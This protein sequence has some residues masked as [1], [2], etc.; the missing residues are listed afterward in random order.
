MAHVARLIALMSLLALSLSLAVTPATANDQTC[1]HFISAPGSNTVGITISTPGIYCLATDVIM[2]ASF[3][4]GN[5]IEIAANYV[6]L[7]L[8]GHKVHGA[9][10]GTATQAIGIHAANRQALTIKNG[11]VWGFFQG[12][13]LDAAAY[14]SP[15]G[16]V[17]EGLRA[18]N[19][20][21][22]GIRVLGANSIIRNNVV[23]DTGPSTLSAF[24]DANGILVGGSGSRVL[25][26]DILTV[27]STGLLGSA[28]GIQSQG[29]NVLIVGN[30]ITTVTAALPANNYG[31]WIFSGPSK[32]RD[33]LT[34]SVGIPFSTVVGDAGGN[35]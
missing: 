34:S 25:N 17:V 7:D 24:V 16:N 12:V 6:T 15:A 28:A 2:A 33:N 30:R 22:N 29:P 11:I 13:V 26:N 3:K 10:A 5:A 18:R 14:T 19:N 35:N 4:S 1:D 9:N 23:A 31:V 32:Y 8:N 20:R 21:A 27:T